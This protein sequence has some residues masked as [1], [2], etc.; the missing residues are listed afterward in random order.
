MGATM[1]GM[2]HRVNEHF[3]V[4]ISTGSGADAKAENENKGIAPDIATAPEKALNAAY[5]Q[6]VNQILQTSGDEDWKIQLKKIV[7]E[8]EG[9]K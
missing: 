1:P 2:S 5:L 7:A 3:T 9:E 4:W 6:A 8:I